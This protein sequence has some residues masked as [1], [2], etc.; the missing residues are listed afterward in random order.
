MILDLVLVAA[1]TVLFAVLAALQE[2]KL[3]RTKD[4]FF[5]NICRAAVLSGVFVSIIRL[6][7]LFT[8]IENMAAVETYD[9]SLDFSKFAIMFFVKLRPLLIG[10]LVNVICLPFTKKNNAEQNDVSETEQVSCKI[11]LL[12]PR[13]KEVA[14]L[15]GR[16]YSNMQ[17]ADEL[18]ISVE[19]VKR[20]LSTVFEKLEI[21]SRHE[22]PVIE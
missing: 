7:V 13:E 19:T 9:F 10:L 3:S 11:K 15:A 17:I 1:G 4:N 20:H 14:R 2:K 18:F 6:I 22:L 16:G 5:A 12:S 21:S 8:K